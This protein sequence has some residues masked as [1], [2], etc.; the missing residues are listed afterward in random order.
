MPTRHR[1]T[2]D[3]PLAIVGHVHTPFKQRDA[4]PIQGTANDARG[5]VAVLP[6]FTPGLQ[7]LDGFDRIWLLYLARVEPADTLNVVPRLDNVPRGVFATR[8]LQRPNPIGL[9]CVRLVRVEG[10][11]LYVEGVDV[12]DGTPVIDLKPYVPRFDAYPDAWAGWLEHRVPHERA[13]QERH[14]DRDD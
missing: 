1:Q 14:R 3:W 13:W 12:L 7:D 5:T 4:L 9:T 6:E 10:P 11:T 8:S 2:L